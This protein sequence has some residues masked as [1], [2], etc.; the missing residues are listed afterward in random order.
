MKADPQTGTEVIAALQRMTDAYAARDV[1]AVLSSFAADPDVVLYGTGG[2]EKRQGPDEIRAQAERDWAQS[3]AASMSLTWGTVSAAGN[4]A[5]TCG[6]GS[7]DFKAGEVEGSLPARVSA[8]L[9]KRN[10]EWLIVHSHFSTP[11]A[12]QEEGESF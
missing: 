8:V 6:D 12:A 11:A 10:G 7:F 2:D 9:E 1:Q 3:D 5:W 4:V